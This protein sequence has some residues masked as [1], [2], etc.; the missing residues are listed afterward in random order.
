MRTPPMSGRALQRTWRTREAEQPLPT[1]EAA[2]RA[3]Y[4]FIKQ[5][6][7]RKP[8]PPFLFVRGTVY[9]L[10]YVNG[11]FRDARTEPTRDHEPRHHR[12]SSAPRQVRAHSA[13]QAHVRVQA[14]GLWIMLTE[15]PVR[16]ETRGDVAMTLEVFVR[17]M[18]VSL[19]LSGLFLWLSAFVCWMSV[20]DGS[21]VARTVHNVTGWALAV[22]GSV[23]VAIGLVLSARMPAAEA[24]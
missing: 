9:A 13:A 18:S 1:V 8:I 6:D 23:L 14:E 24:E 4:R 7:E 2:S 12:A 10:T 22:F 11:R 19:A 20:G 15:Q 21:D 5:Y 17:R 3:C 16:G